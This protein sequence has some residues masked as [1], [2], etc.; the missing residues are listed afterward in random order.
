MLNKNSFPST[1]QEFVCLF[2]GIP[3]NCF[4]IRQ[5]NAGN[6]C[7]DTR[8]HI[9][10]PLHFSVAE[11]PDVIFEYKVL[12]AWLFSWKFVYCSSKV[13]DN[14]AMYSDILKH[15]ADALLVQCAVH[16]SI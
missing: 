16:E 1:Q 2:K 5:L 15:L 3:L 4:Q 12:D 10:R 13:S 8:E 11:L 7:E 14:A 9:F 6:G